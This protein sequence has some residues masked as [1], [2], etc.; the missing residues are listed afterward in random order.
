MAMRE[1]QIIIVTGLSGSGKSIAIKCFEDLG[2]YCIDNLPTALLP[3]FAELCAQA[4]DI[5][6]SALGIDIRDPDFLLSFPAQLAALRQ[7][8]FSCEILFLEARDEVLTRR[9]SETRRKHPLADQRPVLQAITLERAKLSGLRALADRII[10]TSDYNVHQ[11]RAALASWYAPVAPRQQ[12]TISVLS[13]GY[14]YGLPFNADLVFDVRFL[15]NPH[16]V[17]HLRAGSGNDPSVV[18]YLMSSQMT[19]DFLKRCFDFVQF[20]LPHYEREGKAYLTIAFGCTGGRHRSV[21]IA[22]LLHHHLEE[23]GYQMT[24]THRDID[25]A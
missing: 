25:K 3:T 12:M 22:N 2:F 19:Q 15:P 9:Y 1:T 6:R 20:L 14:K 17:E 23:Q 10:D 16:F 11:L 21:A 8:G 5:R 4:S 18:E 7:A 13:F 24:L